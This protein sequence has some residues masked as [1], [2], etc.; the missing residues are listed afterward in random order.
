MLWSVEGGA[1]ELGLLWV[2][3]YSDARGLAGPMGALRLTPLL[4][5]VLLA[6]AAASDFGSLGVPSCKPS[7]VS[8]FHAR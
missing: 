8:C 1:L 7:R 3:V 2:S 5:L 6:A 4:L